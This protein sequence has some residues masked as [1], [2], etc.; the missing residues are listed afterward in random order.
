MSKRGK[1]GAAQGARPGM[2]FTEGRQKAFLEELAA[3]CN[4]ARS[5][6]TIGVSVSA[7]YRTRSRSA[8][9]RAGWRSALA[10]GYA[11]LEVALLDRA[12]NG[13]VKIVERGNGQVDKTTDYPDTLGLAL[14]RMHRDTVTASETEHDPEVMDEVRRRLMRKLK[15]VKTRLLASGRMPDGFTPTQGDA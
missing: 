5:A 11:K 12:L 15:A 3:T 4:V 14:L 9:F 10:E 8:A 1:A 2:R 6:E 13:S 7:V